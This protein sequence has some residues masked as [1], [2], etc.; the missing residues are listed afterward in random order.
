MSKE[1]AERLSRALE[2]TG[3]AQAVRATHEG[4]QLKVLCRVANGKEA[5]WTDLVR[6]MLLATE[7]EQTFAHAWR[8][9]FCRHYFLKETDGEKRLVFGWN[10]SIASTSMSESLDFLIRVIKGENPIRPGVE[11]EVTEM[12]LPGTSGKPRNVPKHQGGKGVYPIGTS[13][14]FKPSGAGR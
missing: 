12:E 3:L 11:G 14:S 13:G 8:A 10:I 6:R 9:H 1:H 2:G 4:D 7:N 5:Q